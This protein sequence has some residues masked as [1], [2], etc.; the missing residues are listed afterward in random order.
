MDNS[1]LFAEI[2]RLTLQL[3]KAELQSHTLQAQLSG[4]EAD[5]CIDHM[6]RPLPRPD[7][8]RDC[9]RAAGLRWAMCTCEEL[10]G[11]GARPIKTPQGKPL[12]PAA[13][14]A[15]M[16]IEE[17]KEAGLTECDF[18]RKS[19]RTTAMV[20]KALELVKENDSALVTI[21]VYN[22]TMKKR[23]KELLKH[24]TDE[25]GVQHDQL[26]R[27]S[28]RLRGEYSPSAALT[29]R[30][31]VI[32]DMKGAVSTCDPHLGLKAG[33]RVRFEVEGIIKER[34]ASGFKDLDGNDLETVQYVV[35]MNVARSYY[36]TTLDE[37]P[38]ALLDVTGD[39]IIKVIGVEE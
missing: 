4:L 31:N 27:V 29:L 21:K 16:Q 15:A 33:D 8:H 22:F 5:G 9:P 1:E 17:N 23:I 28:V 37:T 13:E 39:Q 32:D 2:G 36:L 10:K 35:Q 24:Y 20:L 18:Q 14:F 11:R 25:L 6:G 19:G 7:H 38:V 30:D 34:W 3:R 26:S 12:I